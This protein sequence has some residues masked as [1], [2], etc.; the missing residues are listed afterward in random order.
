M[1]LAIAIV[2]LLSAILLFVVGNLYRIGS[3][4]LQILTN[5]AGIVAIVAA[6]AV[7]VNYMR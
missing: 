6:M 1:A 4:T 3:E 2:L 7:F 5:V